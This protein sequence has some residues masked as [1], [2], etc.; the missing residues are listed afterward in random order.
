MDVPKFMNYEARAFNKSIRPVLMAFTFLVRIFPKI[1]AGEGDEAAFII[2]LAI[3]R[4]SILRISQTIF[5]LLRKP[6]CY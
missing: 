3:I 5:L 4:N 6:Q 1:N 2:H